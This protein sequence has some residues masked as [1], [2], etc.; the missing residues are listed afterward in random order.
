MPSAEM[1]W[2]RKMILLSQNSHSYAKSSKCELYC[3]EAVPTSELL[4]EHLPDG[5][6]HEEI[7]VLHVE[8]YSTPLVTQYPPM[9]GETW[10]N[11][12][13]GASQ[14]HMLQKFRA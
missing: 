9:Y 2:P 13:Q 3:I 4:I 14:E 11:I 5:K 7:L 1:T 8:K 10:Q 6:K 12:C